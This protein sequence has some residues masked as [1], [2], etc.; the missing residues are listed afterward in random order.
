M[1]VSLCTQRLLR[2][3]N[4][5]LLFLEKTEENKPESG[6]QGLT[7][8]ISDM[9]CGQ[10]LFFALVQDITEEGDTLTRKGDETWTTTKP[11]TDGRQDHTSL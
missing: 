3:D 1:T 6:F 9:W 2:T 11:T 8:I 10:C 5:Q 4:F 7:K